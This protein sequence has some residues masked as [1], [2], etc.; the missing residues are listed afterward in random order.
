MGNYNLD[1]RYKGSLRSAEHPLV[2]HVDMRAIIRENWAVLGDPL[3]VQ[4]TPCEAF[5]PPIYTPA[6]ILNIT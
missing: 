1:S 4:R 3:E 6:N 5:G 2:I